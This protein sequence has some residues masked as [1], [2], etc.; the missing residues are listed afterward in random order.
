MYLASLAQDVHTPS[1]CGVPKWWGP[2]HAKHVF[3]HTLGDIIPLHIFIQL[4]ILLSLCVLNW[5]FSLCYPSMLCLWEQRVSRVNLCNVQ[6]TYRREIMF[7]ELLLCHWTHWVL[8]NPWVVVTGPSYVNGCEGSHNSI[9]FLAI[10][11]QLIISSCI[12]VVIP[13]I[14]T[15]VV[16]VIFIIVID[17][18]VVAIIAI[19]AVIAVIAIIPVIIT[20]AHL[21]LTLLFELLLL[22]SKVLFGTWGGC[23]SN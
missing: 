4:F 18:D 16:I 21:V 7:L 12:L 20:A 17:V 9:V 10:L 19:I 2:E 1:N 6:E 3:H 5:S 13:I 23:I 8:Y 11:S 15:V 22:L 14:V